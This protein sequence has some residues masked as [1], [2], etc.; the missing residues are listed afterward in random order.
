MPILDIDDLIKIYRDII[1]NIKIRAS[2]DGEGSQNTLNLDY[3]R[4]EGFKFL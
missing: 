2:K 3:I 4:D 1:E